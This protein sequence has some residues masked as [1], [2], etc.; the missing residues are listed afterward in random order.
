ML[1]MIRMKER[2]KYGDDECK[3]L[4]FFLAFHLAQCSDF[5]QMEEVVYFLHDAKF[6]LM[7]F[8]SMQNVYRIILV[9]R[10]RFAIGPIFL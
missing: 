1:M 3:T 8:R 2:K 5:E 7:V 9:R 6:C 4:Q 10:A